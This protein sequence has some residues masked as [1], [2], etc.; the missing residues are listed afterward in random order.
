MGIFIKL[1]NQSG[2]MVGVEA[3]DPPVYVTQLRNG[4]VAICD[5][6]RDA[7]GV[8]DATGSVIYQLAGRQ[9]IQDPS[10]IR[11]A[12][13]ITE[14]EY[15]ELLQDYPEPDP[16]PASADDDIAPLTVGQMR[17][18]IEGQQETIEML[19]ACVLEMSELVY[20]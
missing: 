13:I 16:Q 4:T 20:G 11:T 17:A 18:I 6:E 19:T 10:I 7:Q 15:D 12:T 1:H 5:R 14:A 8:Q 3:L 2:E 9:I